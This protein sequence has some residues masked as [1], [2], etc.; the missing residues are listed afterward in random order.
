MRLL[1]LLLCL[2]FFFTPVRPDEIDS[3]IRLIPSI[4][5]I[6][7][8]SKT[9]N[10]IC[11]KMV[12]SDPDSALFFGKEALAIGIEE[13][14]DEIIGKSYNRIGIVYDVENI[15]DTALVFYDSAL[16]YAER[17]KD[18]ITIASAYNNIGLVYWNKSY[19]DKAV[20]NFFVSLKIFEKLGIRRGV[21][22]I[23]NNIGLILMEQK[24]DSAALD[25]QFRGL[26]IREEIG[27]A[28]GIND[29]RL[30]IALLYWSTKVYDS[31]AIYYK[32][33]IPFY[34]NTKN[35]YALGT[36]YNGLAM[37]FDSEKK[38]DSALIYF[39]KAISE[40]LQVQNYYKAASS[41]LNK[42]ATYRDMNLQ[43]KELETLLKAKDLVKEESSNRVRS[44]I[45]FQLAQIYYELGQYKEASKLY[46]EHKVISDSLYDVNRD[47]KIEQI[48]VQYETERREKE[49]LRE[50][51]E[52]ERLAKEKA[53]AEIRVYNR[54]KWIIGIS[55]VSAIL[56][57][58]VLFMNQRKKRKIQ[59]EKDA[60]IIDEREKGIKA[61]FDAQEEERQRIAK[62]LHDGVGQQISAIKIHLQTISKN[63]LEKTKE[64]EPELNKIDKMVTDT[65]TEIRSI[66][67]QMMPRALTEL[68]LVAALEDM[69]EK[70]FT[71]SGMECTFEHHG[72]KER[73]PSNVEIGLYRIAQELVNNI[74]KHAGAK[75][76]DVQLM[77]TNLH[78]ILVVQDDGQGFGQTGKAKGIGMMNINNRLRTINGELNM[79][80]D[81]GHGTTATIRIALQKNG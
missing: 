39:D 60:A 81:E 40:H 1:L 7:D 46:L 51:A 15:W 27:D 5:N 3:L 28:F 45:L 30:N 26:R 37:V 43:P 74:I 36:A 12:Y 78:C 6:K 23:Y 71:Y 10:D 47:E 14:D 48:K 32:R 50:K 54:N 16:F 8:K 57:L 17:A 4:S 65:G 44:K 56:I 59:S 19:Y 77:K 76:V 24:R 41:L 72:L 18:S 58:V 62:D 69:I 22:N 79:E 42:A 73:L 63:I 33:A 35:H 49:L 29:S 70:S 21:A 61:V 11:L 31:S 55:S 25:Y 52:N 9:L 13:N 68:G 53:L 67:H 38:Y 2:L 66:S 20:E 80:S 34:L 64:F 75:K